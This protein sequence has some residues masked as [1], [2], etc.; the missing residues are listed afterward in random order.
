M[1]SKS[2]ERRGIVADTGLNLGSTGVDPGAES[3]GE[4]RHRG[5]TGGEIQEGLLL[6]CAI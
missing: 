6:V 4:V 1:E 3:C 2:R 5:L